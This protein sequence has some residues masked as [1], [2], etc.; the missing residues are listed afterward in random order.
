MGFHRALE[1][2]P[3]QVAQQAA[4]PLR[5]TF[6]AAMQAFLEAAPVYLAHHNKVGGVIPIGQPLEFAAPILVEPFA[7]L[8]NGGF[9]NSSAFSYSRSILPQSTIVGR[10]CSISWK[11]DVLGIAHP[12]HHISTHLFTFR[13]HYAR[14]I[15]ARVGRAPTPAPFEPERGPVVIGNDVWIGQDVLIQQ[16]VTIGDGAVVAAGSVVVKDV[17]PFAIVG[18]NPARIIRQRFPD[19]LVERIRRVSW[20]QYHVADFAGL[21]L[22]DPV[23]FL[24]GLEERVAAGT[25]AP[26]Q[27]ER[28]DLPA[29]FASLADAEDD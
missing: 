13:P 16:G 12:M 7:T 1:L 21:D 20:W 8:E 5:V 17:P 3:S 11:V 10:F 14:G 23:R 18:G 2:P 4:Y 29:V 27:P 15:E 28:I 24:D 26:W 19:E 22:A 25:I 9:W 6:N